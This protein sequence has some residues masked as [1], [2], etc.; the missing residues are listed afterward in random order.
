MGGAGMDR[1]PSPTDD[2]RPKEWRY[3][4]IR[5][6]LRMSPNVWHSF[7]LEARE[8]LRRTFVDVLHARELRWQHRFA[9]SHGSAAQQL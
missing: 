1:K 9:R 7:Y 8:W 6:I 4:D 2:G 3:R 5:P